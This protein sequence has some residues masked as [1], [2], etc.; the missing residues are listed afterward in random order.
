MCVF[1]GECKSSV[2]H[3]LWHC[4]HDALKT[5]RH[6][7]SHPT[8]QHIF[9]L[10]PALP[11]SM[12]YGLTPP[13]SLQPHS[14]WWTNDASVGSDLNLSRTCL[15]FAGFDPSFTTDGTFCSWLQQYERL[16]A[17]YAFPIINRLGLEGVTL[18]DFNGITHIDD[19]P[20]VLPNVYTDG[21][22][23]NPTLTIYGLSVAAAWWPNRTVHPS[24]LEGEFATHHPHPHGM[25]FTVP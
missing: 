6:Q 18:S 21:S 22:L 4:Q 2:P 25:S 15:T 20:P 16:P 9:D 3:V 10:I 13:L 24:S 11:T 17:H 23:K 14:P 19:V 8:Q 1:C 7:L 5:A 12:L